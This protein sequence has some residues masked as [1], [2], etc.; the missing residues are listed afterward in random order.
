MCKA[1]FYKT[2]K[3]VETKTGNVFMKVIYSLFFNASTIDSWKYS[4]P[5]KGVHEAPLSFWQRQF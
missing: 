1:N 4:F 5:T 3:P 2:V